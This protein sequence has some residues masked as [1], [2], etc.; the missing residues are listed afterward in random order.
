MAVKRSIDDWLISRRMKKIWVLPFHWR[1]GEVIVALALIIG[2]LSLG[3]GMF[4][5]WINDARESEILPVTLHSLG[6]ADY[7][8]D[9]IAR[10]VPV[11]GLE[12][13]QDL[14][15][16]EEPPE[17]GGLLGI[18]LVT[19]N[20]PTPTPTLTL[21]ISVNI[22]AT[23]TPAI[24]DVASP[25]PTS[26]VQHSPTPLPID[27]TSPTPTLT[28]RPPN[29][30]IP[31]STPERSSTN[32]PVPTPKPPTATEPIPATNTPAPTPL[33]PPTNP[34]N[35]SPTPQ[36]VEPPTALPTRSSTLAV[37]PAEQYTP[38]VPAGTPSSP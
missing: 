31:S 5:R 14:L 21:P 25:T 30:S 38:V 28:S 19:P 29:T 9:E 10:P 33:P 1:G 24:K 8:V 32:T 17:T 26:S 23:A 6:E 7:G 16:I 27:Q 36:P 35:P 22:P 2:I 11:I 12:I 20:E 15:G 18:A 34:P 37:T 4:G 13:I 3:S